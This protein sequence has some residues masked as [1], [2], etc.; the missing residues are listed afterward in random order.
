[1]FGCMNKL[2]RNFF[3]RKRDFLYLY[4]PLLPFLHPECLLFVP[5]AGHRLA[6]RPDTPWS[7]DGNAAPTPHWTDPWLT[8]RRRVVES[9]SRY[10]PTQMQLNGFNGERIST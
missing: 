9:G 8:H 2:D 6:V 4:V 7:A 5:A 10:R 1:M 3:L